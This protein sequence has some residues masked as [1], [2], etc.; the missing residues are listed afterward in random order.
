MT[1]V[2]RTFL[3]AWQFLTAIPLS[4]ST[5]DAKPEELAASMSW[6]PFVGCLLGA[7]LVTADLF[8]GRVFSTQVTS[9][10][11]MLLLVVLTRGLHQDGLADMVDGLAGGRTTQA[12]LAI[13]KD[14]HIGAIGA[15]GLF[16]ALGLRYAGLNAMPASEHLAL[17][18]GMPVVGRW[19]MVVGA[20]HVTSARSEGGLA[21]PFLSHLSWQHLSFATVTAGIAL[22][23]L[24]GPWA[25]L[26]CLLIGT[27]LVRLSTAWFQHMFGGVTGDLLGATNEVAEILFI[28]IVPVVFFR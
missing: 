9:M 27:V 4:R 1:V 23:L 15:T 17:L 8:L 12:R 13:M 14:A 5:H 28:V 18:I 3:F 6:Y 10:V 20:F 16:V 25:A 22:A 2:L 24:L 26:G 21:Q 11:L 7:V 19:A